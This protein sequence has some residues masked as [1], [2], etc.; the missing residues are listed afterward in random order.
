MLSKTLYCQTSSNKFPK[1]VTG[2][3]DFGRDTFT[4]FTLKQKA[5]ILEKI[6]QLED[7][8][9]NAILD[10]AIIAQYK[11]KSETDKATIALY[12][13]LDNKE[14]DEIKT[15]KA[16]IKNQNDQNDNLQDEINKQTR[17]ARHFKNM[18]K[19]GTGLGTSLGLVGGIVVGFVLS[20]IVHIGK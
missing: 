13:Q 16:A 18:S 2:S 17:S 6:W 15:L 20:Q 4:V 5:K 7:C 3:V 10:S 11:K 1:T 9:S 14:G 8:N 12:V 19:L